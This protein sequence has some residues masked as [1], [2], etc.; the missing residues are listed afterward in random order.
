MGVGSV[1]PTTFYFACSSVTMRVTLLL[2]SIAGAVELFYASQAIR[3]S[4]H[5]RSGRYRYFIKM[6]R[7]EAER[8]R[9]LAILQESDSD[10]ELSDQDVCDEEDYLNERSI[11]IDT[12]QD[13]SVSDNDDIPLSIRLQYICEEHIVPFY[14]DCTKDNDSK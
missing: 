9:I 10:T 3:Y 1:R 11:S 7:E 5:G 14:A 2:F 12:E 4:C 6:D 8:Q 13:I